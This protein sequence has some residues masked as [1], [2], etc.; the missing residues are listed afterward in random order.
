MRIVYKKTILDKLDHHLDVARR[1]GLVIECI[2]LDP[3]EYEEYDHIC[4]KERAQTDKGY[5]HLAHRGI[6]IW[7][8]KS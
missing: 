1:N 5:W 3:D 8:D 6:P 7:L 2:Y 4:Y